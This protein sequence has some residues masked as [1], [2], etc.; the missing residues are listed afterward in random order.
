MLAACVLQAALEVA[1]L[2]LGPGG[3]PLPGAR[4]TAGGHW[5]LAD[6]KGRFRVQ[7]DPGVVAVTITAPGMEPQSRE[8]PAVGSLA[9]LLEPEVKGAVVEV[10]EGSGY[11]TEGSASALSRQEIYLTP[12][13]AADVFQGVKA[14]P[15][16]SNASEGAELHVRGGD[17]SEVG[18]YLNGGRLAHPY[19]HPTTQGGIFSSVDTALVTAVT[20]IPGGFSAR[21]GD[22][23]SAILD[24]STESA[25]R[26]PAGVAL[27]NLA[28]QG[29]ALDQPLGGGLLRGS[30]RHSDPS[31]LNKWYSMASTFEE[32]PLS[33][34]LHLSYQHGTGENGRL[35]TTALLSRDHLGVDL[36]IQNLASVYFNRSD[37]QFLG[38]TWTQTLGAGT[39]VNLAASHT[40]FGSIWSFGRW[41]MDQTERSTSAR[42]EAVVQASPNLAFEGGADLDRAALDPRGQVPYDLADWGPGAVARPFAYGLAGTRAGAYLTGRYRLSD[43]WGV[44]LGGRTDRYGLLTEGTQDLRATVSFKAGPKVTLLAAGGTFHQMPPLAKLD[45]HQGNPALRAFRATHALVSADARNDEGA[46]PWQARLELYRKDYGDLAVKDPL[47]RYVS[48]GHGYAQGVDLLV[49]AR[50]GAWKGHLGYGYMDTR[51]KEDTQPVLG[52]VAASVPNSLTA[53]LAWVPKPGWEGSASYR[54]A[55]GAPVTPVLGGIPDGSG[56]YA[57]VQ[58]APF[59]DRLPVYRRMDLRA[60]RI[61]PLKGAQAVTFLEIMNLLDHH[62]GASYSYSADFSQRRLEESTF[63]RRILVAGFSLSW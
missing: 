49:K 28:S 26:V 31:L 19:H 37:T 52:P 4:V 60:T 33:Q 59:G 3:K 54:L 53:V 61:F 23:L 24:L 56:G 25:S 11:S 51:R 40:R 34:D 38:A 62:N 36:R 22:A 63:S 57:P 55:S 50:A 1:G 46:I 48:T 12:G 29:L 6:T 45:P 10:V 16:V 20:F 41:G 39:V 8:I 9:V 18:I 7:V 15:G 27:V 44:S 58:G 42:A 35:T 30:Y 14:L 32:S 5:A 17:P 2:V 47:L 21:Y 13:A 43:R